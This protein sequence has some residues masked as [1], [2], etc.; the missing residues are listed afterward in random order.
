MSRFGL[1]GKLGK[2]DCNKLKLKGDK[3]FSKG[4][5]YLALVAYEDAIAEPDCPEEITVP[6]RENIRICKSNLAAHNLKLAQ[7]HFDA[8]DYET[9]ADFATTCLNYADDDKVRSDAEEILK[10]ID[11]QY[12][13]FETLYG[14]DKTEQDLLPDDDDAY[15]EILLENYPPFIRNEVEKDESLKHVMTALNREDLE[16][17]AKVLNLNESP[18]VLYFQALYHSL[19][20]DASA[21]LERFLRLSEGYPDLLDDPRWAELIELIAR[22][23]ADTKIDGILDE[24]PSPVVIRAAVRLYM[25]REDMDTAKAL[26]EETLDALPPHRQDPYLIAL[27]GIWH[28]QMKD[29]VNTVDYLT[30][31]QNIMAMSGQFTLSPEYALPLAIALEKTDENDKALEIALHTAKIY[32]IPE[33]VALSKSLAGKSERDDLKKLAERL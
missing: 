29:F 5:F 15:A 27:T 11:E 25:E 13:Q 7:S 2:K 26:L 19:N 1:F 28:F 20:R 18:A 10:K 8:E 23:G 32:G 6:I 17:G 16:E 9:A 12:D 21:A 22:A 31:F 24:H 4:E 30:K 33:A 14:P 3:Q